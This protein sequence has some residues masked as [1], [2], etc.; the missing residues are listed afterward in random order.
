[1]KK[2]ILIFGGGENQLTLIKASKNLSVE[3]VV[4]D[5]D[6]N[7]PGKRIADHF[8]FV[9]SVD[10]N[11]TKEIALKYKIDGIV[12][13][14]MENPLILMSR[15]AAELGYIFPSEAIIRNCRNKDLMKKV[16]IKSGVPCAKGIRIG[17]DEEISSEKLMNFIYPLIIKPVD[18]YSSRGVYKVND[19]TELKY[20]EN[21]SRSFSSDK[22][23][24][25]EEFI[26]GK[27]YS[28]ESLTYRGITKIIQ[29]TEKIIT[30]YPYTVEIGH[31]QPAE[32]TRDEKS[33]ITALILKAINALGIENSAA[34]SELMITPNGPVIIE[35]GAR[36]GGDFISSYLTLASTG[37]NMD[38]GAIN[39][40]L[41]NPPETNLQFNN[42]SY[43]KYLELPSGNIVG[44]IDNWM[45][46]RTYP[47]VVYASLSIKEG[48]VIPPVTD[49]SKRSGF[50]IVKGGS[51]NGVINLADEMIKSLSGFIHLNPN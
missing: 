49:S 29:I 23:V 47:G 41:G 24:I 42:F 46:I 1:M 33:I 32:L 7:A 6:P 4:I 22:S 31:I 9:G 18:S 35:I 44:K 48:Q 14:Q 28:V 15:L 34:H 3:S 21:Q 51:R 17:S 10:Y 38:E 30:S 5:P 39:I 8:E 2:K 43:I 37:L 11:R 12:T 45:P 50:V 19:F 20:F 13:S 16:F 36:L 40:A 27:E 26:E 25:I